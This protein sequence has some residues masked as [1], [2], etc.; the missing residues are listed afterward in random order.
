MAEKKYDYEFTVQVT[1]LDFENESQLLQLENDQFAVVPFVSEGLS[2]LGVEISSDS[3]TSAWKDFVNF[4]ASN[5]PEIE[6]IRVDLD[7]VSMSQIAERGIKTREAVRL[8]AKGKRRNDF[9]KPFTSAGQ[10]LL[11][12]WSDVF[13]WLSAKETTKQPCP[14][15]INVIERLNGTFASQRI[16]SERGWTVL[17]FGDSPTY[18]SNL[19]HGTL[20]SLPGETPPSNVINYGKAFSAGPV[21]KVAV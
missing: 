15:P 14:L 6:I 17:K 19:E 5:A 7:L 10:S 21:K 3:P 9:P 16:A 8:W 2:L 1:G 18:R 4:L 11:W 20:R 13:N 12:A